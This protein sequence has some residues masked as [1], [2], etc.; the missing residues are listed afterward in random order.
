MPDHDP[1]RPDPGS[2]LSRLSKTAAFWILMILMLVVALQLVRGQGDQ[3][4]ELNYTEFL[5]QLNSG[6]STRSRSRARTSRASSGHPWSARARRCTSSPW[7][8][9]RTPKG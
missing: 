2:R 6:T 7:S 9:R 4:A 5:A 1:I 3:A 8:C